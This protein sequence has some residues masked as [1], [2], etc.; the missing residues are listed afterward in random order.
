MPLPVFMRAKELKKKIRALTDKN[1]INRDT[2]SACLMN[3]F[4]NIFVT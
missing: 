3:G 2:G 4:F 1:Q